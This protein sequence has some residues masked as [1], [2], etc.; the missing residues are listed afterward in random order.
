MDAKEVLISPTA[1]MTAFALSAG[2]IRL[3]LTPSMKVRDASHFVQSIA[4]FIGVYCASP[5]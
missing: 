2:T 4:L 3:D 1:E 5:P